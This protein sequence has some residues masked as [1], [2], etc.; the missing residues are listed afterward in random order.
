[1]SLNNLGW[2]DKLTELTK[3]CDINLSDVGRI[4]SQHKNLY[5]ISTGKTD[6]FAEVSGN[7]MFNKSD[8]PV[9]GDWVIITERLNEKKATIHDILP[10]YSKFSRSS[11][12]EVT[13][14]QVIA[15]NIDYIFLVSSLNEEFNLRRIERYL[16]SSWDSGANPIIVLNKSDL[17]DDEEINKK[18]LQINKIAFGINVEVISA[19]TGDGMKSLYKYTGSGKTIA[20]L[21]SS[22]TG[23][24]TICNYLLNRSVQKVQNVR[25]SDSKGRHTTTSRHLFKMPNGGVLI[26]TPGMRELQLWD[27]SGGMEPSFKDIYRLAQECYYNDCQHDTEPMCK[28]KEAISKGKLEPNRLQSYNKLKKELDYLESRHNKA[29]QLELKHKAKKIGG[30]RTR[31]NRRK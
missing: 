21:G 18:I 17:C 28:V 11:S 10:R 8:F 31:F 19:T 1:M 2:N 20:L 29:K 24:S 13:T 30:D 15:S 16:I 7:F 22:G 27:V 3:D 23:K 12:G 25:A 6:L 14:E 26:D 5:T 4:I 9:V